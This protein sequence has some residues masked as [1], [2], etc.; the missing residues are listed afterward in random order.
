[1]DAYIILNG[2]GGCKEQAF[3]R[4]VSIHRHTVQIIVVEWVMASS[5]SVRA[6]WLSGGK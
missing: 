6:E 4:Y 5:F 2:S 3:S 1:M